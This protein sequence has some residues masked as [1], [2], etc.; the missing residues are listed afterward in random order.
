MKKI[1]FIFLVF[2]FYINAQAINKIDDIYK[3]IQYYKLNNGLNVYLLA[4]KKAKNVSIVLKVNVGTIVEDRN[5]AGLTHLVEHLVF[6]DQR[7]PHKDYFD[8]FK[9]NGATYVNAFTNKYDTEYKFD[10]LSNKTEF[11]LSNL[12]TMIFDKNITNKDLI[13]EK[14]ALQTE[15]GEDTLLVDI[16]LDI[17]DFTEL[18]LPK[19][20]DIFYD[21]FNLDKEK[22][23]NE[24]IRQKNNKKFTLQDVIS[25]YNKY[26]YPSNMTLKVSGNF[27]IQ[28]IKDIIRNN[29]EKYNKNGTLT[30]KL[31]K[32]NAQLNNKMYVTKSYTGFNESSL[33]YKA[34]H[35]KYISFLVMDAYMQNLA[36]RLQQK[37]RNKN[38]KTYSVE[39]D[40][41]YRQNAYI[42]TIVFDGLHENF[43]NNKN[44]IEKF[45]KDDIK[46]I[47]DIL[48]NK[49]RKIVHK[50]YL[51]IKHE[52]HSLM[53][54]INEIDN[55]KVQFNNNNTPIELFD[56]LTN[57]EFRSIIR[58]KCDVNNKYI[59]IY[60]DYEFFP[61]DIFIFAMIDISLTI[62]ILIIILRRLFKK[63]NKSYDSRKV[64]LSRRLSNKVFLILPIITSFLVFVVLYSWFSYFVF[65]L[66]FDN[67][68]YIEQLFYPKLMLI[69]ILESSFII[70][71]FVYVRSFINKNYFERLD[72]TKEAIF[73]ISAKVIMIKKT[74]IKSFEVEKWSIN[75]Y[76]KTFGTTLIFWRKLL[77][78]TLNDGKIIY[79]KSNNA[80]QLKEDILNIYDI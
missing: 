25:H 23:L 9:E 80:K 12:S 8:Y 37:L 70:L 47:D 56:N 68:Y 38:G 54:L 72:L 36:T 76:F 11:L 43:I 48:I 20:R 55:I 53:S 24:N 39:S 46:N 42:H 29:F 5:T 15:I 71:V 6:R 69:N 1:Y 67:P 18:I 59:E 30:A 32:H 44:Y 52:S 50:K 78:I 60:K 40:Y 13:N 77:K 49:I 21:D 28:K 14:G 4:D 75:K 17:F 22:T 79:C 10:I 2:L 63:A 51:S 19:R 62:Y 3:N 64:V 66:I 73:L 33:G 35:K 74:D 34:I 31:T 61:Y 26:Y 65:N 41:Y 27:E 16:F 58:D 57:E 7:V 45:M